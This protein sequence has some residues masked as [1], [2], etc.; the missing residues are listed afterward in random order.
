M[1]KTEIINKFKKGLTEIKKY[2]NLYYNKD[3]PAISDN[4]YDKLKQ[5]ILKLEKN[6][7]F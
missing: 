4:D 3:R 1:K 2:N 7:F 6:I 5:E